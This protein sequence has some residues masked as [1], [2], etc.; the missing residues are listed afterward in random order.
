ML[1]S[2]IFLELSMSFY[3]IC[4][5]VT[6]TVICDIILTSNLKFKNKKIN[7]NEN[8]NENK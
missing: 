7:K 8:R 4:D 2:I 3:I 5:H 6:M 1:Y